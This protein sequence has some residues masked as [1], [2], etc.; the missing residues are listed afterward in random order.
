MDGTLNL[1]IPKLWSSEFSANVGSAFCDMDYVKGLGERTWCCLLS[2]TG[3]SPT[4]DANNLHVVSL[5]PLSKSGFHELIDSHFK[6]MDGTLNLSIPKLWCFLFLGSDFCLLQSDVCLIPPNLQDK[7][8]VPDLGCF[9]DFNSPFWLLTVAE[10][11]QLEEKCRPGVS[12]ED[13]D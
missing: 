1:S 8:I 12:P 13:F 10:R 6:D 11:I 9:G 7:L 3:L 4:P 5:D 2:A